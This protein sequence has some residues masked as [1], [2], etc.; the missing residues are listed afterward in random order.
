M[1]AKPAWDFSVQ[2]PP[3]WLVNDPSHATRAA[4]AGRSVDRYITEYPE[5]VPWR[6]PLIEKL[7]DFGS[8]ADEKFG[9]IAATTWH[10]DFVN[11]VEVTA[12]FMVFDGI[13][14]APQSVKAEL[15][16]LRE[17]LAQP[18][19]GDIG[20]RDV[21]VVELG[22]GKAKAVRVRVRVLGETEPARD[23]STLVVDNVDHY[24]PRA[25]RDD[26]PRRRHP[27]PGLR[28]RAG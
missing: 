15:A 18:A 16:I 26:H 3:A 22:E 27:L 9:Y 1:H 11:K 19:K 13:R 6:E 5:Y 8:A 17:E 28:R 12:N 23:G 2:F 10:Y 4:S 20:A 25:S 7:I 21:R 24:V 14:R